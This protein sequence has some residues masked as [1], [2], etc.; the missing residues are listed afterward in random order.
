MTYQKAWENLM[1]VINNLNV[2]L[3][4]NVEDTCE[5]VLGL[6]SNIGYIHSLIE[7]EEEAVEPL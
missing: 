4:D 2:E 7:K 5:E 1:D 6:I 3:S